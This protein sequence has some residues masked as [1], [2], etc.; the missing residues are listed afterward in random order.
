MENQSDALFYFAEQTSP[1]DMKIQ[2]LDTKKHAYMYLN[3]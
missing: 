1:S 2:N 3:L